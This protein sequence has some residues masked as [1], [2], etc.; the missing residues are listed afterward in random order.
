MA[1]GER[2]T[3]ARAARRELEFRPTTNARGLRSARAARRVPFGQLGLPHLTTASVGAISIADV[4]RFLFDPLGDVENTLGELAGLMLGDQV[5]ALATPELK[6]LRNAIIIT[7]ANLAVIRAMLESVH[8]HTSPDPQGAVTQCRVLIKQSLELLVHAIGAIVTVDYPRRAVNALIDGLRKLEQTIVDAPAKALQ[9]LEDEAR[10]LA[11][12]VAAPVAVGTA[13]MVAL[14]FAA[15]AMFNG[16]R[17]KKTDGL[18][19]LGA[20][21]L[22]LGGGTL[23]T[24]IQHPQ[25]LPGFGKKEK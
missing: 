9:F 2:A 8:N 14:G 22:V 21:A 7:R 17:S 18:L 13:G 5:A 16:K 20:A 19:L 11:E 24:N 3:R 4:V 23:F 6:E 25:P 12:D 1:R 10:I 15:Y